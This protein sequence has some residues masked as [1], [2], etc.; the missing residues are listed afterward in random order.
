M[1]RIMIFQAPKMELP[2]GKEGA[3]LAE[4][5][6]PERVR[7]Y[8]AYSVFQHSSVLKW[9]QSTVFKRY[10]YLAFLCSSSSVLTTRFLSPVCIPASPL[11]SFRSTASFPVCPSDPVVPSLGGQESVHSQNACTKSSQMYSVECTVPAFSLW[12]V[13]DP[14]RHC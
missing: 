12:F 2:W 4:L 10:L 13:N 1:H 7:P 14:G 5:G 8:S 6:G 11:L 3:F 9:S